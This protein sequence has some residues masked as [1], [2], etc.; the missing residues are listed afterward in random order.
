MHDPVHHEGGPS[1]VARI[2]QQRDSEEEKH[3]VGE[4]H[5]HAPHAGNDAVDQ[6]R[7]QL[8]FGQCRPDGGAEPGEALLDPVHRR[9]SEAEHHLEQQPHEQDE[10]RDAQQPA[11]HDPVDGVRPIQPLNLRGLRR[12]PASAGGEAVAPVRDGDLGVVPDDPFQVRAYLVDFAQQVG[13]VRLGGLDRAANRV[14]VLQKLDRQPTRGDTVAQAVFL[15]QLRELVEVILQLATQSDRHLRPLPRLGHAL[16]SVQQRADPFAPVPD[17]GDE[18]HADQLREQLDVD[19]AAASLRL[20]EHVER[21]D[22][23]HVQLDELSREVKIALQV[24]GVDDI[25]HH[26]RLR[27]EDE[28]AGDQLFGRVG[29]EAVGAR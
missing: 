13:G 24:G 28:V 2:L 20:V 1:H 6:Q 9:R 25:D 19:L 15:Y 22:Q 11:E 16:Y 4:K 27:V 21:H 14:V 23:R 17:R 26:V 7:T 8:A 29:G 12:L 10:D 5:Q 3:D 18:R